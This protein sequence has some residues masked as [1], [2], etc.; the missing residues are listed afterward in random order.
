MLICTDLPFPE[1]S[2][3]VR[4][5]RLI[6]LRHIAPVDV[7][8]ERDGDGFSTLPTELDALAA[9][10]DPTAAFGVQLRK[11][12]VDAETAHSLR[13]RITEHLERYGFR[14][15]TRRPQQVVSVYCTEDRLLIGLSRTFENLSDW[16]GGMRMYAYREDTISRA[17]FK[18]LEAIERFALELPVN[19]AAL[20]L[21]AAPG[22][23]SKVLLERGMRVLAVDPAELSPTLSSNPNLTHFKGLAQDLPMANGRTFDLLTNDMRMDT[24]ESVE[25]TNSMSRYLCDGGLAIVTFKLPKKGITAIV[26]KGLRLLEESFTLLHAK[27]LFHNRSEITVVAVKGKPLTVGSG[28]A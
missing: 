9:R 17:E 16:G 10:L 23:W 5:S 2:E 11:C 13:R 24:R 3:L 4:S 15:D 6:F 14:H 25:I 19:G 26:N 18:L 7:T 12:N 22:G 21:G 28:E 8:Q 1:F 27:Q 20:D